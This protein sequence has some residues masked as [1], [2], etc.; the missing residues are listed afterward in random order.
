MKKNNEENK[1]ITNQRHIVKQEAN[2]R[3]G[4]KLFTFILVGFLII[5]GGYYLINLNFDRPIDC[6]VISATGSN[7][8]GGVKTSASTP[9]VTVKT[10]ECGTIV[11]VRMYNDGFDTAQDLADELNKKKNER[12][13]FYVGPI[14]LFTWPYEAKAADLE[15]YPI[16]K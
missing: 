14:R 8:G 16:R 4:G 15:G 13:R 10:Q 2:H 1:I 5:T 3:P 7:G 11:F 9:S 6:T 12:V